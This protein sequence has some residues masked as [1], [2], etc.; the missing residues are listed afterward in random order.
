MVAGSAGERGLSLSHSGASAL[1]H[2]RKHWSD[3]ELHALLQYHLTVIQ[4]CQSD[5]HLRELSLNWKTHLEL[6][7]AIQGC[8]IFM[9]RNA[10]QAFGQGSPPAPHSINYPY[11]LC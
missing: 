10:K 5:R 1:K 8:R 9:W 7:G 4:G 3:W 2:S 6:K 11:Y